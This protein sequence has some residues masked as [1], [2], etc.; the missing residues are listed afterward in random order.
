MLWKAS[1]LMTRLVGSF[2]SARLMPP[3]LWMPRFMVVRG[4]QGWGGGRGVL[5]EACALT[6]CACL[7]GSSKA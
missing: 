3:S 7:G 2:G 4:A 5:C 1:A 6:A